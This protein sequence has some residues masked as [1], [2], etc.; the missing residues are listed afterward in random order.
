[1]DS[2]HDA[3]ADVRGLWQVLIRMFESIWNNNDLSFIVQKSIELTFMSEILDSDYMNDVQQD[4]QQRENGAAEEQSV[5]ESSDDWWA[6]NTDKMTELME[7]QE[8]SSAK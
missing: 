4:A 3:L 1:M 8:S 2:A 6:K 7:K 5:E